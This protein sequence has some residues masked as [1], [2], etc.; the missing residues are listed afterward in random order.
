MVPC[1]R[2][3]RALGWPRVEKILTCFPPPPEGWLRVPLS[4]VEFQRVLW[5]RV[6]IFVLHL[7]FG[8]VRNRSDLW[9]I[10]FCG[11]EPARD[12]ILAQD[13]PLF[14]SIGQNFVPGECWHEAL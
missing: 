13:R 14:A 2:G 4:G 12:A 5:F 7:C 11:L 3:C 10:G 6:C 1:V 9:L 8:S